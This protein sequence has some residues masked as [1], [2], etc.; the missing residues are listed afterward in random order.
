M[1]RLLAASSVAVTPPST[2][3]T[4]VATL[5]RSTRPTSPNS[6]R[7]AAR[8]PPI[9]PL[10][11]IL[12]L[13]GSEHNSLHAEAND[14]QVRSWSVGWGRGLRASPPLHSPIAA[15]PEMRAPRVC[16]LNFVTS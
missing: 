13:H 4:V 12:E 15:I 8:R 14:T 1:G 6:P 7:A 2:Q 11:H 9:A 5:P 16:Y 10:V 3:N